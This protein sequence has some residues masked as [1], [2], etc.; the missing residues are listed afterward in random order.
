MITDRRRLQSDADLLVQRVGEA[1]AAGADLVQVRERDLDARELSRLVTRCLDAARG[2]R[3]RLLVNDRLDVALATGAH[4]VHLRS[5]SMSA[6][7]ARSLAPVGF[8]IGRSVHVVDEAVRVAAEGGVDYLLFGAVFATSSKPGHTPAGVRMLAEVAAATSVP[9]LA[10][11]G[12]TAETVKLLAGSGSAGF[13][14]IGWFADGGDGV[15]HQA[16]AAAA[17][18]FEK[19]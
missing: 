7:R 9:V 13:A 1:A 17:R 3:T 11:G 2:T 4:G 12:I 19:G 16:V 18:A 10:V 5:D 14:A 15:A 6:A 8:L